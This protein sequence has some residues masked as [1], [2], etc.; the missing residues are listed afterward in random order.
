MESKN[1]SRISVF[2]ETGG[3][4]LTH[5]L[6]AAQGRRAAA[7]GVRVSFGK[8]MGTCTRN[9]ATLSADRNC[10]LAASFNAN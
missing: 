9:I 5:K 4:L 6:M 7:D 2:R 3:R 10:E 8:H 1:H